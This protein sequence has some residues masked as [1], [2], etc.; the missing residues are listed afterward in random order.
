[1]TLACTIFIRERCCFPLVCTSRNDNKF[2]FSF[3]NKGRRTKGVLRF[4]E[5]VENRDASFI[6]FIVIT[7]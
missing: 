5:R 4:K 2:I 3:Q 1:M 7:K 6:Q